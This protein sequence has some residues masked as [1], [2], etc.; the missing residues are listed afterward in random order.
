[1]TNGIYDLIAEAREALAS[2]MDENDSIS[3]T[4]NANIKEHGLNDTLL[5]YAELPLDSELRALVLKKYNP[6]QKN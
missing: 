6:I 3:F 4:M 5:K 2:S 1:M